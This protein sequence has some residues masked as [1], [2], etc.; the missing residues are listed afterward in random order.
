MFIGLLTVSMLLIS[1]LEQHDSPLSFV[2]SL[3]AAAFRS[4]AARPAQHTK[5]EVHDPQYHGD[6]P[7]IYSNAWRIRASEHSKGMLNGNG[8]PWKWDVRQLKFQGHVHRMPTTTATLL[9]P[10]TAIS[11]GSASDRTWGSHANYSPEGMLRGTNL[12]GG[13]PDAHGQFWVRPV[14]RGPALLSLLQVGAE[15]GQMVHV[16]AAQFKDED[17][18]REVSWGTINRST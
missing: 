2:E 3:G 12:W 10:T 7:A 8:R 9:Q 17:R 16:K 11:S 4:P 6:Q 5:Q 1:H 14:L 18:A 13:R 15:F